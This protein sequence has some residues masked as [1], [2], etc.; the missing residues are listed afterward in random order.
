MRRGQD[1]TIAK[2]DTAAKRL[3]TKVQGHRSL[4]ADIIRLDIFAAGQRLRRPTAAEQKARCE[5]RSYG[6]DNRG[7]RRFC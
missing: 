1:I 3:A 4:G 7:A 5:Q 2:D 6:R